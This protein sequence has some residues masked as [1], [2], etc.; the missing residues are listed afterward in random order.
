MLLQVFSTATFSVLT[1]GV[2]LMTAIVAPIIN[3]IYKP[4]KRFEQ[5]K[6]KTIQKLRDD[7]ELRILACL[8]NARNAN[9]MINILSTFG[10]S[11]LSPMHVYGVY[12]VELTGRS[13]ALVA[14]HIKMPR[15][16]VAGEQNLTKTQAELRSITNIFESFG[17]AYGAV[18]AETL[19][20]VSSYATIH[21]DICNM[22]N[23]KHTSLILLPFH[24]QFTSE[25]ALET[26]SQVYQ[27]INQQ[28]MQG[29][30]CSVGIFVDR[31]IGHF[32][33]MNFHIIMIFVGGPDDREALAV[34]KRMASNPGVRL[35]VVRMLL[36]EEPGED[37]LSQAK[38]QSIL[39]AV[40]DNEV[41]KK[42]DEEYVSSFRLTQV[43]N[44]D[45][46][47]YSEVDVLSA[48][49]VPAV[50]N[51]VEKSGC[52][53]YIVGQG[54][55]RNSKVFLD[56]LE[57]CDCLEL[58]VIGDILASNN[59]LTQASV[60]VVQQYGYGGLVVEKQQ[61]NHMANNSND[62]VDHYL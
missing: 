6:L 30:S 43:N 1:S 22:A 23:E 18:R 48:E 46:I 51:V 7:A 9:S 24:K 10:P 61:L 14:A 47:S 52:D 29:A 26:T 12:L 16:P 38:G 11:R 21:K 8:H 31:E 50:L 44:D 39:S 36:F 17:D 60:L 15:G 2:V 19:N 42:L 55:R 27:K 5:N 35:S 58:G 57:W 54:N 56:L 33:K 37:T 41:Q 13:A 25:G 49:D 20:I 34:A 45:S 28:I 32:S 3:V 59:F 4:R 40:M 53:L 62:G